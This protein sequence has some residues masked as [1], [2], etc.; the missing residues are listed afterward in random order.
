MPRPR[1]HALGV[2]LATACAASSLAA[3]TAGAAEIQV[4]RACYSDPAD[5]ADLVRLSGRGFTPGAPY[6]VT[7][8]DR[9]L[10]GGGGTANADGT[11]AGSFTAP[12]APRVAGRRSFRLDVRQGAVKA[13]TTF[14]VSRL[15]ASFTPSSGPT[16]RLRVRFAVDGFALQGAVRPWV[17]VHYVKAGGRLAHTMRLGRAGGPCGTLHS[18]RRRLFGFP[19]RA[20][21]WRLQ[22]DTRKAYVRGTT[23]SSFLF[24]TLGV[25]VR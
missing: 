8:D 21:S 1:A 4:G 23:R 6:Q 24:I 20:G 2:A 9:V 3:A 19:A 18:A 13:S 7:L 16:R 14:A 22:F 15:R 25:T 10:E 11:V 17:Y 5:R 12:S